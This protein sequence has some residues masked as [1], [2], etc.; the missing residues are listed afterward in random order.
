MEDA[1]FDAF[2]AALEKSTDR[3]RTVVYAFIVIYVAMLIY[4]LNA[5][6]YPARQ[7]IFDEIDRQARCFYLQQMDAASCSEDVQKAVNE[8]KKPPIRDE[9]IEHDFW[10]HQYQTTYDASVAARTFR[11]PIVGL[12]SDRDLLWI[13]FPLIGLIGHYIVWLALRRTALLFEFLF[14]HNR[15]DALRLRLMETTLMLSAPL[16]VDSRQIPRL[17]RHLWLI[18]TLIVF[19]IPFLTTILVMCDQTNV[20]PAL[21]YNR[22]IEHFLPKPTVGLWLQLSTEAVLLFLQGAL[23]AQLLLLGRQFGQS[24]SQLSRA[25]A[26]L[27]HLHSRA[28]PE[29]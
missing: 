22:E 21:I 3:S 1:K 20:F 4:A 7:R 27:E 26:A 2:F 11:M 9:K 12:D 15:R 25:I 24:Q 29:T 19:A 13:I 6:A 16:N 10:E 5:F 14:H 28:Q 17:F 8:L 23:L 18:V